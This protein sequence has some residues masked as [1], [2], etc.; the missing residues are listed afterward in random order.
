MFSSTGELSRRCCQDFVKL[1]L[2]RYTDFL[3]NEILPDGTTVHL[4]SLDPPGRT[5]KASRKRKNGQAQSSSAQA[6]AKNDGLDQAGDDDLVTQDGPSAASSSLRSQVKHNGG[7]NDSEDSL[8]NDSGVTTP[9]HDGTKT[10]LTN[11]NA[12]CP[13]MIL[14]F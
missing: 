3:V 2:Q 5:R 9:L 1:I 12:R 6:G 8:V 11:S 7:N 14:N 13:G 4:T 10:C